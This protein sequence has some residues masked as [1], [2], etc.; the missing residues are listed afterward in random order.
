M[1]CLL[2]LFLGASI[3]LEIVE[4][5]GF[6]SL[7]KTKVPV[8][9]IIKTIQDIT[10]RVCLQKCRISKNCKHAAID[11]KSN[12]CLHLNNISM[13]NGQETVKVDLFQETPIDKKV[14]KKG[15]HIL[16]NII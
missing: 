4:T 7:V 3:H 12:S 8:S 16:F 13:S 11:I 6:Y 9:N 2:I 1:R 14:V 15:T 5:G 10:K